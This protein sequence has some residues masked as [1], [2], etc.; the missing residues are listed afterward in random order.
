[1]LS[2]R[3]INTVENGV[4]WRGDQIA[5]VCLSAV[6]LIN[7]FRLRCT[8]HQDPLEHAQ[9]DSKQDGST[10]NITYQG[11]PYNFKL[12]CPSVL[13][14]WFST[15]IR[16]NK[17]TTISFGAVLQGWAWLYITLRASTLIG[18]AHTRRNR[19]SHMMHQIICQSFGDD[20]KDLITTITEGSCR[21]LSHKPKQGL[22]INGSSSTRSKCTEEEKAVE[23]PESNNHHSDI[24]FH[25]ILFYITYNINLHQIMWFYMIWCE[26]I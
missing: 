14:D 6:W 1:M 22:Y 23:N 15:G 5:P 26:Q 7:V 20:G 25:M 9:T 11:L 18:E 8:E 3:K 12:V 24:Y 10:W 4:K 17:K 2:T 21:C 19:G 16:G 13:S